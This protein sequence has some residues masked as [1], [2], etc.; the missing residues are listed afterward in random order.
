MRMHGPCTPCCADKC[1]ACVY[2]VCVCVADGRDAELGEPFEV[3]GVPAART[4][5]EGISL[6]GR[7]AAEG[8]GGGVCS[9]PF[10]A[11]VQE[12][13]QDLVREER[14]LKGTQPE[15]IRAI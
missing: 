13:R 1:C 6:R 8:Q 14:W 4:T 11:E 2:R 5:G 10:T 7:T 3:P 15:V 12:P 9:S